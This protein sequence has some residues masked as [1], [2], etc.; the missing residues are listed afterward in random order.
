M[1]VASGLLQRI[2]SFLK[3]L[4]QDLDGGS[5]LDDALRIGTIAASLYRPTNE[6][7]QRFFEML[8]LFQRL[9]RWLE[10]PRN[11]S[12]ATLALDPTISPAELRRA[13][14]VLGTLEHP[15]EPAAVSLAAAALIDSSGIRGLAEQFAAARREGTTAL[16]IAL[17]LVS[18]EEETP[19]WFPDSAR[20]LLD[21]RRQRRRDV[22][23]ILLDEERGDDPPGGSAT[24]G[25]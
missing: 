1:T 12:R 14:R 8:I 3:P 20:P 5:R 7:E 11:F 23:R 15:E 21:E 25:G 10:K 4:Y 6:G 22:C 2:E 19:H 17:A 9:G 18:R 24:Q 13:A 16:E